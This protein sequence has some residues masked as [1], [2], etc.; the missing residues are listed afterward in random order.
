M[1][2]TEFTREL[3][4][5]LLTDLG[6]SFPRDAHSLDDPILAAMVK[7][8]L[9]L[10]ADTATIDKALEREL[11]MSWRG[12]LMARRIELD[13][14]ARAAAMPKKEPVYAGLTVRVPPEHDALTHIYASD[15]L[16]RAVRMENGQRVVDISVAAFLGLVTNKT[17]GMAWERVNQ[18]ALARISRPNPQPPMPQ[19]PR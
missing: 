11:S 8:R 14:I 10:V 16:P 2:E 7:S 1:R 12:A 5:G 18:D 17:G 4:L 15:G 9:A 19:A 13:Q 3:L 6:A